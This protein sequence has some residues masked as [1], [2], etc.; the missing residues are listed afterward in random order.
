MSPFAADIGWQMSLCLR[1]DHSNLVDVNVYGSS[2]SNLV[3]YPVIFAN[4]SVFHRIFL[5][6]FCEADRISHGNHPRLQSD[7]I[8]EE[9]NA[10]ADVLPE[11][12]LQIQLQ[13][14]GSPWGSK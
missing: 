9:G 13:F 2:I 5:T 6:K 3:L 8:P 7:D 1:I 14:S 12:L 10:F 11:A 4:L